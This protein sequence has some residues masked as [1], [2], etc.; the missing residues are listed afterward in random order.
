[1]YFKL[2]AAHAST[3]A[4]AL[5]GAI[6]AGTGNATIA[7]FDGATVATPATAPGATLLGTLT[8][9]AVPATQTD[10]LI[11]F[12]AIT[13]DSAADASGTA[14]WARIYD[15]DGNGVF[16]VD[17]SDG[18]GTGA[19]KLNTTTIVAGGPIALTSL[20]IVVGG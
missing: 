15:G 18:A 9:S 17:V 11:T 5:I 19:V 16:D 12:N 13:Q 7:F 8:C 3:L 14:T 1:M 6:A 10:G 20:V 2:L 4:T